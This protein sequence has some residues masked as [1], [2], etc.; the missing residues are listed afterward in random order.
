MTHYSSYIWEY[1]AANNF[2]T[3]Y[4]EAAHKYH[5]KAFYGRINKRQGYKNQICLHNT[6]CINI[7][8]MINVLFYKKSRYT[9]QSG[10]NIEA[11]VSVP[12]Q[13]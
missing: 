8:T 10:N 1:R 7:L 13:P 3:E 11:Q 12:T 9:T 2:D 6:R 5:V 4:S